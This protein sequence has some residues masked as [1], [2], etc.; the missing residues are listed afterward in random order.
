MASGIWDHARA[1]VARAHAVPRRTRQIELVMI[2][3]STRLI[4]GVVYVMLEMANA[5]RLDERRC[6]VVGRR[7]GIR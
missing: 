5:G 2:E 3:T 1:R 7:V 4:W 6:D